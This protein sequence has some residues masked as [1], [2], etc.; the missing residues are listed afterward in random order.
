MNHITYR[1]TLD[2]AKH[3]SQTVLSG[4]KVGDTNRAIDVALSMNGEP[5]YLGADQAAQLR[6]KYIGENEVIKQRYACE[7]KN[8]RVYCKIEPELLTAPGEIHLDLEVGDLKSDIFSTASFIIFAKATVSND[9]EIPAENYQSVITALA[10]SENALKKS[11][12]TAEVDENGNLVF[13]LFDETKLDCGN[14]IGPQGETGPQGEQGPRGEQG[15]KGERGPQGETGPQGER[16]PRGEQGPKGERGPQ[17]KTGPQGVQG[18]RGPQG[19]PGKDTDLSPAANALKG[20]ESGTA[21]VFKDVSPLEHTIGVKLKYYNAAYDYN[22][23][24]VID[25]KDTDYLFYHVN[26][27]DDYPIPSGKITDVDGNGKLELNDGVVLKALADYSAITLTK[28]GKNLLPRPYHDTSNSPKEMNGITFTDNGD[29]SIT[30][31]GVCKS[32]YNTYFYL[33]VNFSGLLDGVT[34]TLPKTQGNLQFRFVYTDENGNSQNTASAVTWKEG[35]SNLNLIILIASEDPIDN[36]T[37]YPQLEIGTTATEYEQ[38]KA[39]EPVSVNP[40]GTANVVGKG[41]SITLTTDTDN[42]TITAEYNRDLNKAFEEFEA[43]L[44][45][46]IL[47]V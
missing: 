21:V 16:G 31:N 13:T 29:G 26:F 36:V 39:P 9:E 23:D 2:L 28:Y 25:E 41:E 18:E 6:A 11:I 47:E 10:N 30:L 3:G 38:Y 12:S 42:V 5:Y 37:V 17:G 46:L 8:G 19:V 7:I 24:G 15:P 44:Q 40:D 35:C 22:D 32:P 34:Y 45:A 27:P 43:K 14:V 20:K 33:A 1:F 4:F